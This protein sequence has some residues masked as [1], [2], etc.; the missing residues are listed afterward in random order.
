[1]NKFI[2]LLLTF[3]T[4]GE[5]KNESLEQNRKK[6]QGEAYMEAT[7]TF[8]EL[9][10][11]KNPVAAHKMLEKGFMPN[12]KSVNLF[13]AE[14]PHFE[15]DYRG[16]TAHI[17]V[18]LLIKSIT[19]QKL[20]NGQESQFTD[21]YFKK[22]ASNYYISD[23][24]KKL[25]GLSIKI[26]NF[27]N[28]KLNEKIKFVASYTKVLGEIKEVEL[29]FQLKSFIHT[30]DACQKILEGGINNLMEDF[31]LKHS[32]SMIAK[33]I[34]S[35]VQ[36]KLSPEVQKI[37]KNIDEKMHAFDSTK[38]G[39]EIEDKIVIDKIM[40]E[41]IPAMVSSV[42][43]LPQEMQRGYKNQDGLEVKDRLFTLLN[44][45]AATI[46]GILEKAK[47][48]HLRHV[49]KGL[50]INQQYIDKIQQSNESNSFI[51][52]NV[53]VLTPTFP[54]KAMSAKKR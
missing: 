47:A 34:G 26:G 33:K 48:N 15:R 8:N 46:D 40:K 12:E 49:E 37:I 41:D 30:R 19:A 51:G 32:S 50:K 7:E 36:E 1:M 35:L 2:K 45:Y 6:E 20:I 5:A 16:E 29:T 54:D 43:L 53:N 10:R 22:K 17:T 27:E 23:G 21:K 42:A 39:L 31:E 9:V 13:L 28:L 11:G 24:L 38:I 4:S 3:N 44:S 52:S 18:E 14:Y 25:M